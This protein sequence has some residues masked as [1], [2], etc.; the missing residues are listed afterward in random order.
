MESIK[1]CEIQCKVALREMLKVYHTSVSPNK[2]DSALLTPVTLEV[3]VAMSI[4]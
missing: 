4:H 2:R 3:P 1:K